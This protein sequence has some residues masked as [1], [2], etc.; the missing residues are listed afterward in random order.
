MTYIALHIDLAAEAPDLAPQADSAAVDRA[1]KAEVAP[2][3]VSRENNVDFIEQQC[4]DE[5]DGTWIDRKS[6]GD[7]DDDAV[8]EKDSA[9][10][11]SNGQEEGESEARPRN[12]ERQ[13]E[14]ASGSGQ[15]HS[16][17]V[18]GRDETFRSL[19]RWHFDW[20]D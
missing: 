3:F 15:R 2:E 16:D 1:P 13:M 12:L 4:G 5:G 11:N 9:E 14:D 17:A 6:K 8:D 10:A 18:S 20:D 7:D 19:I